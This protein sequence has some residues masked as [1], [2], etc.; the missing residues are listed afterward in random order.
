MREVTLARMLNTG[1]PNEQAVISTGLATGESVISEGQKR[2][3][4]GVKVRLLPP[5]AAVVVGKT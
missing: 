2:L 1:Q 3:M 5:A 4:P